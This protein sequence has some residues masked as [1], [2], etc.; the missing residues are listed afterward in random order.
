MI[1]Q[2]KGTDTGGAKFDTFAPSGMKMTY[3]VI[4]LGP[5]G[6]SVK[7]LLT[8]SKMFKKA[9]WHFEINP[10]I[11]LAQKLLAIF[12]LSSDLCIIS[13]T[14]LKIFSS[15][16]LDNFMTTKSSRPQ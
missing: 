9:I 16:C 7:I 8:E 3:E 13:F 10:R 15:C 4:D 5:N 2:S 12:T 6:C 11:Q 14:G 1:P